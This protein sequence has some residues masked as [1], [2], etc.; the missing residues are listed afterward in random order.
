MAFV[1][2]LARIIAMLIMVFIRKER[3]V[4]E[5]LQRDG[6]QLLL[7]I[8]HVGFKGIGIRKM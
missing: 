7:Q 6:I 3:E 1:S 2:N 5:T 8:C 4:L